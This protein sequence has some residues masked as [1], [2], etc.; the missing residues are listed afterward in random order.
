MASVNKVI[1]I[2]NLGKDPE[3]RY[4]AS[5]RAVVNVTFATSDRWKDKNT[6][7]K[8]ER[9]EWHHIVFYSPLA[10]IAGQYL[11]KGSSVY[12]EGRLQ[13]RKW[14][15]QA[16]EDRHTTEIVVG[17]MKMLGGKAQAAPSL[18]GPAPAPA[19]GVPALTQP[20]PVTADAMSPAGD[21]D[22][23]DIPFVRCDFG[24][25]PT[26]TDATDRLAR[27]SDYPAAW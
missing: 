27:S 19:A 10:E 23:D 5:G 4:T 7:E 15:D 17:G 3:V 1:L 22:E 24:R 26:A 6:G 2:G 9:T 21:M 20:G 8:Q 25:A 12:V 18:P 14:Q 13:T 11:R 16:G